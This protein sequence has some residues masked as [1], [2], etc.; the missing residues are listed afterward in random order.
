MSNQKKY[1]VICIGQVVQD[2]MVTNIP[3]NALTADTD[4]IM[5]GQVLLASGGDA[6][7][8]ACMLAKLGNRSALLTRLDNRNVG[9]MIYGDLTRE[10]VDT[11]LLIRPDDCKTFSTVVVVK[12]NGD[13][14]FLIGPGENFMLK[15]SDIDLSVFEETRAVTAGSIYALGELDTGGLAV[16]FKKAQEE[17]AIT[18]ADMNF[19][20]LGL[21]AHA[22][23]SVYPYTDY[24]MPSYDEAVYVTGEK[25]P[26]A[27][28]DAFL[29][30]GVKNVVLKMGAEG[31]FFKNAERRFFTDPYRITPVDTTGCGDN[32]VAAF[33]HGLLKG[34]EPEACAEFACGAG[35]L[36][37]QGIGA[38]LYIESE[39][40][41]RQ[42][43][44][45]TEKTQ[46][47]RK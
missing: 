30:A 6:V 26:D 37:S 10:G 27:I 7:N 1:D 28:A 31:C 13:H 36:N 41:I 33:L 42:F 46:L 29:K 44:A 24:L 38:H 19:D 35:A 8:E 17:G 4:T 9:D 12:E 16:I 22:I 23:D 43:M 3:E 21:G 45:S 25:E 14:S 34:M 32:F 20:T 5:A 2:I 47:H 18:L 11:S 15:M 40:Q 39:E